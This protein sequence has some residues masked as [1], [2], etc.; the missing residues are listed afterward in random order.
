MSDSTKLA[1]KS[2]LQSFYNRIFP[3]LG[4]NAASGF[5]PVGT[6]ISVMGNSAP[7][8]YLACDGSVY[9]I[10]DYQELADYFLQQFGSYNKFGGDGSTTFAVP[11]LRGE[12]LR[13]TGSNSHSGQGGGSSVGTH[14]D[15]TQSPQ[16]TTNNGE[17]QMIV[18][19]H[20]T[21]S[22]DTKPKVVNPDYASDTAD[23]FG[24]V[25]F[26][27]TTSGTAITRFTSR[28]TNTSVL[29]CIATKNIYLNPSLDYSTS[30]KVVGT[31]IDGKP[32][33]QK[34]VQ[35]T[36][37]NVTTEGTP[38]SITVDVADNIDIAWVAEI[39]SQG[40][41][42]TNMGIA[43]AGSSASPSYILKGIRTYIG[44]S[45]KKL[46]VQNNFPAW[47]G[48]T[49]YAIVKYTKTTD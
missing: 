45:P 34:T 27:S 38:V 36:T 35:L 13:G 20:T 24:L 14:Q 47:N 41:V 37:P 18:P 7:A 16:I 12:F 30:E 23:M 42:M 49:Y 39:T 19:I 40:V 1:T 10:A 44:G 43:N 15:G 29:Y 3:Y 4:G 28:P 22:A 31:W 5:T 2:D 32:I 21:G 33:Y 26:D 25:N 48:I 17:R 6:I 8:N 46:Y 11:D 9:N